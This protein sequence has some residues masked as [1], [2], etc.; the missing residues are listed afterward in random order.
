MQL[1]VTDGHLPV[2]LAPEGRI[3]LSYVPLKMWSRISFSLWRGLSFAVSAP[4]KKIT[5]LKIG[6]YLKNT[7]AELNR[8]FQIK[9]YVPNNVKFCSNRQKLD[10]C[11]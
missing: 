11:G 6:K 8:I 5:C 2:P 1:L 9:K 10:S 3:L 7:G 4:L